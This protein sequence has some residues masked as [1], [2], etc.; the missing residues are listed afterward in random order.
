MIDVLRELREYIPIINSGGETFKA[1]FGDDRPELTPSGPY[2]QINDMNS[3][4][5]ANAL[6]YERRTG[7][8]TVTQLF[9]SEAK[10]SFLDYMGNSWF[11][12]PRPIGL[13]DEEYRQYI[14]DKAIG[15]KES[16]A[17]LKNILTKYSVE[18]VIIYESGTA[19][20]SMV[21]NYSYVGYTKYTHDTV[22][23]AV[24][25]PAILG[26]GE[27]SGKQDFFFTVK[28]QPQKASYEKIILEIL[29]TGH[30]AGVGYEVQYYYPPSWW[31]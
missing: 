7:R 22:T 9:L 6:E 27:L 20:T 5:I 4:A 28:I 14:I 1:L 21:V 10:G 25:T 31:V 17:S 30:V 18:E 12:T 3:G 11:N 24:I 13:A 26:A 29:R 16:G 2:A 23:G 15:G 8:Y 19:K